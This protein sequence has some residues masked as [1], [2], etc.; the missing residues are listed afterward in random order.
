[1]EKINLYKY[2]LAL[3]EFKKLLYNDND[4]IQDYIPYDLGK[5]LEYLL[6]LFE[7][8]KEN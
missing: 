8:A 4:D 5:D 3:S 7:S 1:M 2:E 6:L